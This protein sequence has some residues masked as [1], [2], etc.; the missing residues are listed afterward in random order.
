M[1]L[2]DE[3]ETKLDILIKEFPDLD[4]DEMADILE[5]YSDSCRRKKEE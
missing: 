4:L 2:M 5:Y 3:F 1:K